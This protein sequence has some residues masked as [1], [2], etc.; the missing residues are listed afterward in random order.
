MSGI[1]VC[2]TDQGQFCTSKNP[3][4]APNLEFF[5]KQALNLERFSKIGLDF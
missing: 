1:Q 2:V 3:E 4:H 5:P